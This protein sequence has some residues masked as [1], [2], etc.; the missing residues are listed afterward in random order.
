M[1]NH[2]R[3]QRALPKSHRGPRL[4]PRPGRTSFVL[5]GRLPPRRAP[6][7]SLPLAVNGN[8]GPTSG[9]AP[10]DSDFGVVSGPGNATGRHRARHHPSEFAVNIACD[11]HRPGL[12]EMH[13]V[14]STQSP[15]L[16]LKIRT[17]YRIIA[18]FI[19][20]AVPNVDVNNSGSHSVFRSTTPHW[21]PAANPVPRFSDR[22]E[23]VRR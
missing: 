19:D 6:L 15:G 12:G 23:P 16:T 4:S 1:K 21:L 5:S 22:N 3:G 17:L 18:V 8:T 13:A 9:L 14:G 20:K 10:A 11:F 7:R 2:R